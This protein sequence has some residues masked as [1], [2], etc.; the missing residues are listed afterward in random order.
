MQKQQMHYTDKSGH[1]DVVALAGVLADTA[2]EQ[3][4]D[5]PP[6][7]PLRVQ[8]GRGLPDRQDPA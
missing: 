1:L 5:R 4:V 7:Q 3:H 6:V 2:V 8:V